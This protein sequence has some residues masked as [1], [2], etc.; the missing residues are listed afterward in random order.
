MVAMYQGKQAVGHGIPRALYGVLAAE[1]I[2][3]AQRDCAPAHLS[4]CTSCRVRM[5]REPHVAHV[6]IST[7]HAEITLNLSRQRILSQRKSKHL[8]LV[9]PDI[10]HQVLPAGRSERR[11]VSAHMHFLSNQEVGVPLW[12]S[13]SAPYCGPPPAVNLAMNY[14]DPLLHV[15]AHCNCGG[16]DEGLET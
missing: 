16:G 4:T 13:V 15:R 7:F 5:A 6:Y 9:K 11:Y 8:E 3:P 14:S 12:L 10:C 1:E 2:T